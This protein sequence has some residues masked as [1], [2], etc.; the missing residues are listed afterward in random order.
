MK[1]KV[2]KV[3]NAMDLLKDEMIKELYYSVKKQFSF[4][5]QEVE[6]KN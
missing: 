2:D 6:L 1:L 3:D 4:K 5:Y